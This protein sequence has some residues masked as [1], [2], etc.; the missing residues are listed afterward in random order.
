MFAHNPKVA[1]SNLAPATKE[2]LGNPTFLRGFFASEFH[3]NVHV[4]PVSDLR[5]LDSWTMVVPRGRLDRGYVVHLT[6][7]DNLVSIWN[8]GA[9][10]APSRIPDAMQ[11][12]ELGSREIKDRRAE[13]EVPC[14]S[15]VSLLTMYRSISQ[16]E[17]RC[18]I[19]PIPETP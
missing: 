18:C 7:V 9:L 15:G 17:V 11:I 6:S 14:S 2:A 8:A 4:K 1:G 12:D 5:A 3:R 10:L 13:R 19:L 16:H